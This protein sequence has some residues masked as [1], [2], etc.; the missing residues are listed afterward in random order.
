MAKG[1]VANHLQDQAQ[2]HRRQAESVVTDGAHSDHP[3]DENWSKGQ[4]GEGAVDALVGAEPEEADKEEADAT[5]H[6]CPGNDVSEDAIDE[7]VALLTST[8]DIE[9][10]INL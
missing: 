8:S 6:P 4:P 10:W 3:R 1:V 5:E 2:R 9:K 7:V